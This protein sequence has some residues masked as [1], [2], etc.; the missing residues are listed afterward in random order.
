[1][2]FIPLRVLALAALPTL[3]ACASTAP[4]DSGQNGGAGARGG[5][6]GSSNTGGSSSGNGGSSGGNTG[7]S[8]GS[9]GGSSGGDASAS[10]ACGMGKTAAKGATIDNFDGMSQILEWLL[11]DA[12]KPA[13]TAVSPKG[14]LMVPVTGKETLALGALAM[15]A[16]KDRPCMDASAFKGVQFKVSGTVSSLQL[17]F[18]TPATLPLDEGGTCASPACGYAHYSKDISPSVAAGGMV[19]VAFADL[20]VAFGAADP[21]DPSTLVSIVFLTLDEDKTHSFTIDDIAFY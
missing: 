17:R 11:A 14:Q 10:A 18:G 3:I 20:K 16:A 9:T 21:F 4:N 1:M 8:S 6:G 12:S 13:G 19:Q 7:G 15:W 5:N 2:K